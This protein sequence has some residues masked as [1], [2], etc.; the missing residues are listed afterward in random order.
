MTTTFPVPLTGATADTLMWAR[1][2]QIDDAALAQLRNIS[3]LPWVAGLRVMPD[4]HL[5]KGATVG[6][7]I[8]MRDAVSPNA[9]GVDIGCGMIGVKTSLTAADLPEDLG[10][11]RAAIEAAIPVGFHSHE[12]VVDLA[13]LRPV[14]GPAGSDRLRAEKDF[15]SR[16]DRLHPGVQNRRARAMRQMGTLGGGNHFIEVCLDSEVSL[17]T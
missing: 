1:E 16:F 5:G 9:V 14:A 2:D 12:E 11:L 10:Q 4:V 15:W 13:A 6:S 17:T 3:T 7:V 8:A